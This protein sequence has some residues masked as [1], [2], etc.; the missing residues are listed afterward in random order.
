MNIAIYYNLCSCIYIYVLN[1]RQYLTVLDANFSLKTDSNLV[2]NLSFNVFIQWFYSSLNGTNPLQS[3]FTDRKGP[4]SASS[5]QRSA[6]RLYCVGLICCSEHN[7]DCVA[8]LF[9]PFVP[10]LLFYFNRLLMV[11][12]FDFIYIS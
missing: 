4:R 11:S 5:T 1:W 12:R 2:I 9:A 3:T 10:W 6:G 7:Y 8:L